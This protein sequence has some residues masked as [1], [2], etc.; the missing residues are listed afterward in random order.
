MKKIFLS[1]GDFT[2]VSDEDY[3]F[4]V[5]Y[6]WWLTKDGYTTG[7]IDGKKQFMHKI[8]AKRMGLDLSNMIDH[9]DRNRLNHC[10]NNL[11]AATRSQ[12]AINSKIN[13]RNKSGF[14]GVSR[15]GNRWRVEIQINNQRIYFGTFGTPEEAH[16]ARCRAAEKYHGEFAN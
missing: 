9:E 7:W 10:R 2:L 1:N 4:L 11:R 16:E 6:N 8:I 12:N 14:K 5:G 15:H 13:R 3:I